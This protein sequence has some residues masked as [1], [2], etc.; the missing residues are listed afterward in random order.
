MDAF[1]TQMEKADAFS[2][3]TLSG[4][5]ENAEVS[6]ENGGRA[7]SEIRLITQNSGSFRPQTLISGELLKNEALIA[8]ELCAMVDEALSHILFKTPHSAGETI[9]LSGVPFRIVGVVKH[10]FSPGDASD[11]R[12][13]LPFA[14]AD[15]IG[16][17]PDYLIAE[18]F[19]TS[20]AGRTRRLKSQWSS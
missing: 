20:G 14:A 5:V 7:Q 12:I 6:T 16:I 4:I 19:P 17:S 11:F 13:F 8:G 15:S 10:T 2:L 3:Y 9:I 18:A 1:E